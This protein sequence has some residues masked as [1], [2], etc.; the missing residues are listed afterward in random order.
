MTKKNRFLLLQTSVIAYL[1]KKI[2]SI[3]AKNGELNQAKAQRSLL[4][5]GGPKFT[6]MPLLNFLSPP[7]FSPVDP[8]TSFLHIPGGLESLTLAKIL[9]SLSL[10]NG[11]P[12]SFSENF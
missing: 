2:L 4:Y 11:G 3:R 1:H 12:G 8:L 5:F 7:I 9:R 10:I 6:P